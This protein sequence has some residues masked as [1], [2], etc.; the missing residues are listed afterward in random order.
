MGVKRDAKAE[1]HD[2]LQARCRRCHRE[3]SLAWKLSEAG[4]AA[5]RRYSRSERGREMQHLRRAKNK[6]L[7]KLTEAKN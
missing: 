7:N 6:E 3:T 4:R 1:A 2:G 5:G